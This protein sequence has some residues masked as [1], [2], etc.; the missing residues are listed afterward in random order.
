[1][2]C[3]FHSLQLYSQHDIITICSKEEKVRTD[4]K[5]TVTAFYTPAVWS[6]EML[7]IDPYNFGI[8]ALRITA[9]HDQVSLPSKF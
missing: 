6:T 1:M 9:L 3:I 4:Y 7:N 2:K 8:S 5:T